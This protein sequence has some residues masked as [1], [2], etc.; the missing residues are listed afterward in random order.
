[1]PIKIDV[2]NPK[3]TALLVI[4]MENDFV[5]PG[6]PFEV[7][8]AQKIMPTLKKLIGF[9][10]Q[11]GIKVIYTTHVHRPDGSDMGRFADI[12][13][14][15][16][17]RVGLVDGTKGIEIFD[18]IAPQAG[19]IVIKKHRYSAFFGTDLNMVLRGQGVDTVVVAGVTTEDCCH[20]TARDAMFQD[21]KVLFLSDCTGTY[22]YPDLGYGDL[23]AA[24]VHRSSL[25]IL[26]LSTAHVLTASDFMARVK[27]KAPIK[28]AAAA[29]RKTGVKKKRARAR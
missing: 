6:A 13:P 10:R 5:A 15:I 22:D 4:D 18:E 25:V 23:P 16:V 29:N 11:S 27:S 24:E 12:Y 14:A 9:C 1:M 7:K 8:A 17:D 26:A 19:E 20:A 3:T 28:R 21:Y 2:V